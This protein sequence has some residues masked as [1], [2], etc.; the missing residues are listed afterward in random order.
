MIRQAADNPAIP[1]TVPVTPPAM[2]PARTQ[3]SL[4]TSSS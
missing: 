4:R 2:R 1:A 3:L